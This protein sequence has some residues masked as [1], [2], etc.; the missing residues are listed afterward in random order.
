MT[1]PTTSG[2]VTVTVEQIEE[3]EED[4]RILNECG[5]HAF[6]WGPG[7]SIGGEHWDQSLNFNGWRWLRPLLLELLA[8]RKDD[9]AAL[10]EGYRIIS[11]EQ[12]RRI[13]HWRGRFEELE[14]R[15]KLYEQM[16]RV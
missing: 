10:Q 6:G 13:K 7:I 11:E 8:L 4:Q 3:L 1:D 9:K 16:Q 14:E 15:L 5:A 12:Q 2:Y